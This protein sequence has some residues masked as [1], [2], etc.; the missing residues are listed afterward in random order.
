MDKRY[1]QF[2]GLLRKTRQDIRVE[3]QRLMEELKDPEK[4]QRVKESV[5]ELGTWARHTAEDVGELV[6]KAVRKAEGA[7]NDAAKRV[8]VKVPGSSNAP[9]SDP[10]AW[11]TNRTGPGAQS[12]QEASDWAPQAHAAS[13]ELVNPS[14][15]KTRRKTVGR[16]VAAKKATSPSA[17]PKGGAK[18]KR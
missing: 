12:T 16:K 10:S 13:P 18:R 15:S 5:R 1:E 8:G 6:E 2:V 4:Q 11:S 7:L 17:K 9:G 14:S 3:V